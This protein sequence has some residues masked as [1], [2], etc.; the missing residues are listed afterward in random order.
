MYYPLMLDLSCF[1][2]V[3]IGGGKIAYQKTKE[4]IQYGGKVKVISD[5]LNPLFKHLEQYII[6]EQKVYQEEQLKEATLVIAATDNSSINEAIGCY[7]REKNILC[8]VITSEALSSFIVPASIQRGS[9]V[10]SVS[11]GGKSPSL[12][13][14]IKR[15]LEEQYGK[16]YEAYLELLGEARQRLKMTIVDETERRK[17]IKE[18]VDLDKNI[19]EEMIR[20]G[21]I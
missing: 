6:Y 19:L 21:K 13:K 10:L 5:K 12:S 3:V 4:L 1:K 2:I 17:R 7:C 20:E 18:L 16:E 9:L 15:A 14:K 11:T 8:N